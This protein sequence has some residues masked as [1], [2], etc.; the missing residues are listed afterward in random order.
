MFVATTRPSYL[1]TWV[2]GQAPVTSPIAHSR[3]PTRICASTATPR[4]FG[5]M[6]TRLEADVMDPRPPAG[7][8]E[9]LLAA[10]LASVG[11]LEHVLVAVAPRRCRF[12]AEG[13][14][15]AVAAQDVGQRVP[16]WRGLARE[17]AR[18]ARRS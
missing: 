5:S 13:D 14:L 4:G 18:A 2:S 17:Q 1:P 16:E 11:E 10:Q 9:Q 8:D 3:S 6:P 7:R 12:G 15:D